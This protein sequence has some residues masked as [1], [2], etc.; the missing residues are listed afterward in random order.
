MAENEVL[1]DTSSLESV[2]YNVTVEIQLIVMELYTYFHDFSYLVILQGLELLECW[3]MWKVSRI[4]GKKWERSSRLRT[5]QHVLKS[6][7]AMKARWEL[8]RYWGFFKRCVL[9]YSNYYHGLLMSWYTNVYIMIIIEYLMLC[10][11][12]WCEAFAN[13]RLWC[14]RGK[15]RGTR[16]APLSV[17]GQT[18]YVW[19]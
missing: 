3:K 14:R 6:S 16:A 7:I 8:W 4:D 10:M 12:C 18:R 13:Q 17:R 9:V 1:G 5:M 11:L 19:S 15:T 2:W